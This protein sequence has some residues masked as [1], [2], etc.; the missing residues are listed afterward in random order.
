MA[1][2]KPAP[3]DFKIETNAD[4]K[5]PAEKGRYHLYVAYSCPFASRSL[6]ARNLLGLEDVIGLSVAHRLAL[7]WIVYGTDMVYDQDC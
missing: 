4:A 5:F 6:A 3:Y 2:A 1:A 7:N